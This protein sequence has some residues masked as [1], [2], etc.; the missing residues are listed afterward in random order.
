MSS[1]TSA[2]APPPPLQIAA[3]PNFP[4][5]CLSTCSSIIR[6]DIQQSITSYFISFYFF[7]EWG[8]QEEG[9]DQRVWLERLRAWQR[10]HESFASKKEFLVTK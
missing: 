7:V 4:T 8:G 5:F 6:V 3:T 9:R 2:D 10:V 1:T